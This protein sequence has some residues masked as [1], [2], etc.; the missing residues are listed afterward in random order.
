MLNVHGE[1]HKYETIRE[2]KALKAVVQ[3][4]ENLHQIYIV[5]TCE[6]VGYCNWML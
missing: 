1:Y 4:K 6:R 5:D 2:Y 3:S